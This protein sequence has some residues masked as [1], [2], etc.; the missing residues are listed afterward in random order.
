MKNRAEEEV[1]SGMYRKLLDEHGFSFKTLNWGSREGQHL[2]FSVLAQVADL[3]GCS[4]LDVGCGLGDLYGWSKERG[5]GVVYTGLDLT[6][7]LVE[8]ARLRH[9][10]GRFISGSILD[11]DIFRGEKFDYVLSS[12]IFYTYRTGAYN[13]MKSAA[14]RMWNL[15]NKGVAFN[16]LSGWSVEKDGAEFY[17][18]PAETVTLCHAFTPWVSMRHDYHPRDFTMYMYRREL[19]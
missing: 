7:E 8:Q 5:L 6:R 13:W 14:G 2:R 16:T 12:G 18:D 9:P 4:V 15:C 19:P 11:E 1:T 3:R 17:A 10:E